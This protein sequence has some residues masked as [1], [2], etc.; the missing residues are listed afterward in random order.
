MSVL[1]PRQLSAKKDLVERADCLQSLIA[2]LDKEIQQ[3]FDSGQVAPPN[4]WI[5][6]YQVKGKYGVMKYFARFLHVLF[7]NFACAQY[8][9]ED[10]RQLT[11]NSSQHF[12]FAVS[13]RLLAV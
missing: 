4:S 2:Q 3:I 5:V 8:R 9:S 12:R 11:R 10:C 6:R 7:P 1:R 13:V